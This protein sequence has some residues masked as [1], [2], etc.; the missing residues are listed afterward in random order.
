MLAGLSVK[1]S[2]GSVM[3]RSVPAAHNETHAAAIQDVVQRPKLPCSLRPLRLCTCSARSRHCESEPK[4]DQKECTSRGMGVTR[5]TR[6]Q[7]SRAGSSLSS[8]WVMGG[9]RP[10]PRLP[11]TTTA[12]PVIRPSTRNLP[13]PC[14][15]ERHSRSMAALLRKIW[16]VTSCFHLRR[17]LDANRTTCFAGHGTELNNNLTAV[18]FASCSKST[19]SMTILSL[20]TQPQQLAHRNGLLLMAP[21]QSQGVGQHQATIRQ[22]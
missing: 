22:I 19:K 12:L 11:V 21:S 17:M 7:L 8:S 5:C 9:S 18:A 2:T 4:Q 16:I 3:S 10:S 6:A 13:R 15:R 20:C 14:P 1:W